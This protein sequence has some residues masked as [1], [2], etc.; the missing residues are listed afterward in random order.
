MRALTLLVLGAALAGCAGHSPEP[1]ATVQVDPQR[2]QGTW[3]ELA[4]KPMIF[5][6]ACRQSEAHYS[7]RAD[8]SLEVL[9]RCRTDDGSWKQVVGTATPQVPGRTDAFWV[10]F[11]NW[12]TR[13]FPDLVRGDYQV[14]YVDAA[15]QTALVGSRDRDY[16]WLLSRQ[17]SLPEPVLRRLL[18]EANRRGYDTAD[19]IWR[20]DDSAIGKP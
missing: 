8:G 17:P 1:P 3:Y 10:R 4:R 9:N 14:L 19:L 6:R 2:Y 15:Y 20:S 16:L 13:L 7:L 12:P 11:D 5:Q 18:A